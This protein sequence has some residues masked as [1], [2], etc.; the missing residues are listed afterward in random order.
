MEVDDVSTATSYNRQ[1]QPDTNHLHM[2]QSLAMMM[3]R[4]EGYMLIG[5]FPYEIG[6]G[7]GNSESG[8]GFLFN[9]VNGQFRGEDYNVPEFEQTYVQKKYVDDNF[10]K[11]GTTA[12]A[13]ATD[14]GTVGEVRVTPTFIY[15]CVA[16]DTWV[17]AAVATW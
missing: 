2:T 5:L 3:F 15:T 10:A 11:I 6:L 1:F 17:R 7:I 4:M 14:T 16:T 9:A 12:P 13:S 8:K